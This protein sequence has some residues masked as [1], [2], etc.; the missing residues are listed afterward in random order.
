M[1]FLTIV[2]A[3]FTPFLW[4]QSS[5]PALGAL[6][7]QSSAVAAKAASDVIAFVNAERERAGLRPLAVNP[8]LM[9][10]AR[11]QARQMV[12]LRRLDHVLRGAKYPD[13]RARFAAVGYRYR[14]AAENI[15]WNQRTARAVVAAWMESHGHRANIL[16]PGLTETGVAMVRNARGEPYWVQVFGRPR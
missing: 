16:D 1:T 15:A 14:S 3:A 6:P 2:A 12:Q 4:A 5:G 10:A 9:E 13:L 8:R 11:I 7:A